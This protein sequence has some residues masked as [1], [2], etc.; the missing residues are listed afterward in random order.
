MSISHATV[1]ALFIRSGTAPPRN[2]FGRFYVIR[3]LIQLSH[4]SGTNAFLS[5]PDFFKINFLEKNISGLPSERQ[6]DWIQIRADVLSGLIWIK[7]FAKVIS[8]RQ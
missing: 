2:I 4:C 5:S 1:Q 7:M 3:V 6:T 8:R